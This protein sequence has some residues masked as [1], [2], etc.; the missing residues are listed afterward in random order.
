MNMEIKILKEPVK[1]KFEQYECRVCG[2]KS[3]INL[4]DKERDM[5]ECVFCGAEA[6]NKRVFQIDI[7][8]IGEY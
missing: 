1:I 8:G 4:E 5:I 7:K 2:R 6:E 3:Y